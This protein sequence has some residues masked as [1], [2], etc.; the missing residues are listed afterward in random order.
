MFQN[1][2]LEMKF[3]VTQIVD[4][5]TFEVSPNWKWNGKE[6]NIVRPTGYD[7]PER[8]QPGYQ[9][10]KDK[11]ARL[12]LRREVELR[13]PIKLTYDRLLCDVY[14]QERNLAEYFLE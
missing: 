10:A 3:K 14:Y 8:G 1:N 5:D 2:L 4:G 13:N 12:I 9:E 7:T 6:G 11:L